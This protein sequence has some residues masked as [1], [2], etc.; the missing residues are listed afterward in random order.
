[1]I[2]IIVNFIVNFIDFLQFR[3]KRRLQ[4]SLIPGIL[5]KLRNI[6]ELSTILLNSGGKTDW[7]SGISESGMFQGTRNV[8][9]VG[10]RDLCGS[11]LTIPSESSIMFRNNTRISLY[12]RMSNLTYSL[13]RIIDVFVFLWNILSILTNSDI[14]VQNVDYS[15]L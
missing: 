15:R 9:F 1:M 12:P 2:N 13:A 11:E 5:R 14:P 7:F 10:N 3:Q 6:L 4:P 8:E